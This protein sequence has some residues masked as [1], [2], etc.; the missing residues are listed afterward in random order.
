[1]SPG[2]RTHAALATSPAE[3][4]TS[5]CGDSAWPMAGKPSVRTRAPLPDLTQN[6][7]PAPASA[8]KPLSVLDSSSSVPKGPVTDSALTPAS[9]SSATGPIV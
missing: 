8:S 5:A 2:I 4:S 7:P 6:A 1:M 3:S 9:A